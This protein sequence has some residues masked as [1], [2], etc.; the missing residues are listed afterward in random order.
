[1][2][3]QISNRFLYNFKEAADKAHFTRSFHS[4]VQKFQKK[5][6]HIA[7]VYN[8]VGQRQGRHTIGRTSRL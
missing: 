1:M 2:M 7:L 4:N 8:C 5:A 6:T 3:K